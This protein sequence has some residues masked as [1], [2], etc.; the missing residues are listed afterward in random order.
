M[1]GIVPQDPLRYVPENEVL[2]LQPR[3]RGNILI[4]GQVSALR[5]GPNIYLSLGGLFGSLAFPIQID[6]QNNSAQGWYIRENLRFDL[7]LEK[8]VV[9]SRGQEFP[10]TR[11][12]WFTQD[13]EI[14][15]LAP[16]INKWMKIDS[17]FIW[18]SLLIDLAADLPFPLEDK[19]KRRKETPPLDKK[20]HDPKL[21]RMDQPYQ[22]ATVPRA[23][24]R[25]T[26]DLTKRPGDAAEIRR[27]M[28][29]DTAGDL[30]GM[31]TRTF[32]TLSNDGGLNNFR[33]T[34][35]REHETGDMMGPFRASRV[36]FGDLTPRGLDMAGY[37]GPGLGVR[38]TNNKDEMISGQTS[39]T[40][41][42]DIPPDWDVELYEED[43]LIGFQSVGN[44][45]RYRFENVDL[46]AGDN[47]FRLVFYGP[48]GEVREEELTLP[49]DIT[50]VGKDNHL[51]DISLSLAETQTFTDD[52]SRDVDKNTPQMVVTYHR[53]IHDGLS[54][55]AGLETVQANGTQKLFANIG[56]ALRSGRSLWNFDLLAD[57]AA[58]G[59][60]RTI[61]R[62][63]FSGHDFF[64]SATLRTPNYNPDG[65]DD[66]SGDRF[67]TRIG[68]RG[69][70]ATFLDQ[71][72]SY[73]FDTSYS[74]DYEENADLST[75]LS[76]N[77]RFRGVSIGESLQYT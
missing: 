40:F 50:D 12:E 33:F 43:T 23:N 73:H 52:P 25:I 57:D 47:N 68:L 65:S 67:E 48:Q 45:G 60:F 36:E 26:H 38:I 41:E 14:Y 61:V 49:I 34:M 1:P 62:R 32:S 35:E 11:D 17:E 54:V 13:G 30:L 8:G 3:I 4:D 21:P 44:D 24:A 31:T 9:L 55:N 28:R 20:D 37:V 66:I 63:Q 51:Y 76:L 53:G 72:I 70:I 77:T 69:P 56:T 16:T 2:F 42:G 19:L 75:R 59:A 74:G 5:R 10:V 22:M 18:D 39:R 71:K 46:Y 64:G 7:D 15:V 29:L 6:F 58:E 27:T